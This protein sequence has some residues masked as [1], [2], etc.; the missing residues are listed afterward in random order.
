MSPNPRGGRRSGAGRP[1]MTLD[2]LVA[3]NI[4]LSAEDWAFVE[5]VGKGNRSAGVRALVAAM[6]ED[7]SRTKVAAMTCALR[8]IRDGA[9]KAVDG[10]RDWS[11][12]EL[13]AC[14]YIANAAL[15]PSEPHTPAD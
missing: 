9:Q 13:R 7:D 1:R 2:G 10:Q 3:H 8:D 14:L 6:R 15:T 5:E 4:T 11:E 12:I